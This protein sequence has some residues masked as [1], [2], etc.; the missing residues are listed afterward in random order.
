MDAE[1]LQALLAA[2]PKSYDIGMLKP[3]R[4]ELEAAQANAQA[5]GDGDASAEIA[6]LQQAV[7]ALEKEQTARLDRYAT[8]AMNDFQKA[9][10]AKRDVELRWIDD[11]LTYEGD[12]KLRDSK[13]Y[14]NDAGDRLAGNNERPAYRAV[15]SR[16]LRYA[17]RLGDM[18]LPGNDIP[19]KVE[20]SPN[21]DPDCFPALQGQQVDQAALLDFAADAASRMNQT[22][23]DQLAEQ[24]FQDSGHKTILQGAK[25]GTGII[26]GPVMDYRKRR[27]PKGQQS[28]IVLDESP[29]PGC[30]YVDPWMFYDDM[31]PTLDE[32]SKCFEVHLMDRR[33]LNDLK[34]YPNVIEANIDLLL[35]E[36]EPKLPSELSANITTRNQK[37]DTVE[38]I[39][40]RWAVIEMHGLMD[41]EDVEE[42]LGQPWTDKKSLPLVEFW[43]CDGKAIKCKLSPME[44]DWRVPYYNFTPFPCDDT[45]WGYGIPRMGRGGA[46]IIRGALDATMRNAAI[47][48]GPSIA[49]RKGEV[50]PMDG[51]WVFSGPKNLEVNTDGDIRDAIYSFNVEANVEGN[52]ALLQKG[53]DFLNGDVSDE[54]IPAAG[55]LQVINLRTIFQRWIATGADNTWFQPQGDRWCQWNIQFNPDQSIKGDF[56]VKGIAGSTLVAKDLQMQ[57]LQVFMQTANL[58]AYAGFSN[59]Y[60]TFASFARMLDVP[61]RDKL[62]FDQQTAMKNQQQIQQN[63]GDPMVAVKMQELQIKD[64]QAQAELQLKQA[65]VQLAHQERMAEIA[66]QEKNDQTNAQVQILVAQSK[67]DVAI[68]QLA[69]E[70]KLQIWQVAAAMKKAGLDADTKKVLAEMDMHSKALGQQADNVRT[71]ATL[72][73]Q[74]AT[75]A[76]DIQKEHIHKVADIA[77]ERNMTQMQQQHEKSM[78]KPTNGAANE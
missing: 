69:Q 73:V 26:K 25:L 74:A 28:E 33:K 60:E 76:A 18:L 47:A 68:L 27:K 7:E 37:L 6:S 40:D 53:L 36:E 62:V 10:K 50:A 58:P 9:V 20:P 45:I 15:R 52:L 24:K 19:M 11:C 17:A 67:K 14:P 46:K 5:A 13:A 63:G 8:E 38:S 49:F 3:M 12:D 65:E 4:K 29:T 2:D 31:S 1:A 34:R 77:H 56:D 54:E 61:N 78:P 66:R 23:K 75:K 22:I 43:F 21:P 44:C 30:R 48:S 64:K 59:N 55:L 70:Q 57:H 51:Q 32:C 39:K 71:A 42:M 35:K 16:T 41:P 72:G